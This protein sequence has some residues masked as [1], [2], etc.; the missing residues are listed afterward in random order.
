MGAGNWRQKE[1]AQEPE[2]KRKQQKT[3]AQARHRFCFGGGR[4]KNI[5]EADATLGGEG[6]CWVDEDA[7]WCLGGGKTNGWEGSCQMGER[8]FLDEQRSRKATL[9]CQIRFL[10]CSSSSCSK[11]EKNGGAQQGKTEGAGWDN[12]VL[13]VLLALP[14]LA[15][16]VLGLQLRAGDQ[17]M[18]REGCYGDGDGCAPAAAV[19]RFAARVVL[20]SC[21][22]VSCRAVLHRPTRRRWPGRRNLG[23]NGQGRA[24]ET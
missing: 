14:C 15:M 5:R 10:R 2:P 24:R 3:M 7:M 4:Q 23:E 18:E 21:R 9:R 22:V 11:E 16:R 6:R 1:L 12:R 13:L 19:V 8:I 20:L 17:W